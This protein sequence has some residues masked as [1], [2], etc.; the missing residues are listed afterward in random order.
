MRR[1]EI[2]GVEG[3]GKTTLYMEL[4][5][6]RKRRDNW[7]TADEASIKVACKY[8]KECGKTSPIHLIMSVLLKIPLHRIMKSWFVDLVLQTPQNRM[9][10]QDRPYDMFFRSIINFCNVKQYNPQLRLYRTT[11]LYKIS[12]RMIY[13]EKHVFSDVFVI[14]SDVISLG[15]LLMSHWLDENCEELAKSFFQNIP[16][17]AGLIYCKLDPEETL[18]R[19]EKRDKSGIIALAHRNPKNHDSLAEIDQL[20]KIIKNQNDIAE[21]GVAVLRNRGVKI[22]VL[23]MKDE[24]EKNISKTQ[25]FLREV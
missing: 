5:K 14:E 21:I 15:G 25:K 22:L 4:V 2:L 16:P 9:I 10:L 7:M 20:K 18:K 3:I 1:V 6:R 19:I 23:D 24:L 17:P 11:K 8:A 13:L 12:C